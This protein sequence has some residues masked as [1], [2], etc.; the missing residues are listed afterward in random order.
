MDQIEHFT[1]RYRSKV[2]I[3]SCINNINK[4]RVAKT[5]AKIIAELLANLNK[6]ISKKQICINVWGR[7]DYFIR[8]SFDVQIYGLREFLKGTPYKI[9][10]E[11][12][13]FIELEYSEEQ[14]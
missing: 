5:A 3:K 9:N 14:N 7:D 11:N 6:E 13:N 10:T 2:E 1:F 8:R 12:R 4:K